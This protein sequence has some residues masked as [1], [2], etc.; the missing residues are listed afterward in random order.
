MHAC[1]RESLCDACRDQRWTWWSGVAAR[2][3]DAWA[4]ERTA[5]GTP[6]PESG[7]RELLLEL[8]RVRWIADLTAD[9]PLAL[10]LA[11][12]VV[13]HAFPALRQGPPPGKPATW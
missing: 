5:A 2:R 1:P 11:A 7:D 4:A 10:A 6:P 3:G 9:R 8:A 13:W 12:V